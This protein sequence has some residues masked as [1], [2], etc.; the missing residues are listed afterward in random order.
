VTGSGPDGQQQLGSGSTAGR[1]HR[2]FQQPLEG[3]RLKVT[4]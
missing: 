4:W 3:D 1:K 2:S